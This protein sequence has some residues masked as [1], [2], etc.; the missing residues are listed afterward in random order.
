[1]SAVLTAILRYP[2][3]GLSADPL[4]RVALVARQPV[5]GDRR[6]ALAPGADS[7]DDDGNGWRPRGRFAQRANAPGLA[8]VRVAFVGDAGAVRLSAPDGGVASGDLD[9]P[10]GRAELA[11]FLAT[12][13]G[14]VARNGLRLIAATDGD[15]RPVSFSDAPMPLV[16]ILG[17]ET[18]RDLS[19]AIDATVEPERLRANLHIDGLPAWHELGWEGRTLSIGGARLRVVERIVRCVAIDAGPYGARDLP[20]LAALR[21]RT[22]DDVCGVYAEVVD[23]GGIA[24]GDAVMVE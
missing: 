3:K 7:A 8:S 23:G 14:A 2:I 13:A 1:M 4:Q 24:V 18:L 22:G 15:G 20:L 19:R 12:H 17:L 6:W 10:A 11:R 16:S 9:G 5:P 21:R